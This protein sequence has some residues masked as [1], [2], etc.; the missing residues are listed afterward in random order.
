[1]QFLSAE[2]CRGAEYEQ[3]CV[4]SD[5]NGVPRNIVSDLAEEL[6]NGI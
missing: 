5:L 3:L 1:M 4:I 2:A 6:R